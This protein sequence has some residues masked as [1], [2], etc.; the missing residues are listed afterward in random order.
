MKYN[1][2]ENSKEIKRLT[3]DKNKNKIKTSIKIIEFEDDAQK[4]LEY[5]IY[6]YKK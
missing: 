4:K 5:K 3:L 1:L 6:A 2:E